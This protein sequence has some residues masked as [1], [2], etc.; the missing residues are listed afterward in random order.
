MRSIVL[1]GTLGISFLVKAVLPNDQPWAIWPVL[2]LVSLIFSPVLVGL[3]PRPHLPQ[4][5][6]K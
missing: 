2:L 5:N 4:A 6:E 3:I 1:I